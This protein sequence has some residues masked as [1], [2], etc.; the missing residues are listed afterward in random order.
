M[1]K[2][3]F[4]GRDNDPRWD[5]LHHIALSSLFS[6]SS[7]KLYNFRKKYY[8]DQDN[9]Y[10]DA[11]QISDIIWWSAASI[12]IRRA[13]RT[14]STLESLKA[15]YNKKVDQVFKEVAAT[16]SISEDDLYYVIEWLSKQKEPIPVSILFEEPVPPDPKKSDVILPILRSVAKKISYRYKYSYLIEFGYTEREDLIEELVLRGLNA[17][18]QVDYLS[19]S[20]I[21]A[22]ALGSMNH[23]A[24]DIARRVTQ[25]CRSKY[26]TIK[27]LN[28]HN[29]TARKECNTCYNAK[30]KTPLESGELSGYCKFH[31]QNFV[32]YKRPEWCSGY[33]GEWKK[34]QVAVLPVVYSLNEE[35][36]K[37]EDF[38][39][40]LP[41]V[42]VQ[43]QTEVLEALESSGLSPREIKFVRVSILEEEHKDFEKFFANSGGGNRLDRLRLGVDFFKVDWDSIRAKLAREMNRWNGLD[44]W[45]RTQKSGIKLSSRG[46]ISD[47]NIIN[48][49][50]LDIPSSG[51]FIDF[52]GRVVEARYLVLK[53]KTKLSSEKRRYVEQEINLRIRKYRRYLHSLKIDQI[54]EMAREGGIDNYWF[55]KRS[56]FVKLFT[57]FDKEKIA[58]IETGLEERS[59]IDSKNS[60]LCQN[61]LYERKEDL[62]KLQELNIK[63]LRKLAQ[64]K[65]IKNF[66]FGASK[67]E[68][69]LLLTDPNL[70][71]HAQQRL[72]DARKQWYIKRRNRHQ[73]WMSRK[74]FKF[75][76]FVGFIWE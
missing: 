5:E 56:D 51:N 69:I 22:Y 37:S 55:G 33:V 53:L 1:L 72:E 43:K 74:F 76:L 28:Y 67:N 64:E 7:R 47:E 23:L 29:S 44:G 73:V 17:A 38:E 6:G 24:S 25:R 75:M 15:A 16:F 13:L 27:E 34:E 46:C 30:R 2:E 50:I 39:N 59:R 11:T 58:K 48:R 62:L 10:D 60:V 21:R 70:A 45:K 61:N 42:Y 63:Q 26:Q 9:F 31:K 52:R 32:T 49:A 57:E 14:R 65:G 54:R 36:A 8:Y 68:L 3:L 20:E 4:T 66:W 35:I 40:S 71:E 12:H 18:K 19:E 41:G